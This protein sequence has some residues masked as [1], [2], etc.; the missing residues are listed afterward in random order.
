MAFKFG[1]SAALRRGRNRLRRQDE[2][3]TPDGGGRWRHVAQFRTQIPAPGSNAIRFSKAVTF[4]L[5]F[6]AAVVVYFHFR[7]NAKQSGAQ[8]AYVLADST[9]V[10]DT[11]AEVHTVMT[12]LKNNTRVEV[13]DRTAHWVEVK[14]ADGR[15]GWI[16]A[17]DLLEGEDFEA[18]QRLLKELSGL[19]VQATGHTDGIVNLRLEPSRDSEQLAQLEQNRQVEVFGRRLVTRPANP[20]QPSSTPV[21]EAWYLVRT[22]TRAGWL[23]GRF[24]ELDIPP[25]LSPFAA[26]TNMVAW[27]TLDTVNE[28]GQQV[29]QYLTAE[30][31]GTQDVDF[32]HI[33][34]FTYWVKNHRYVTAYVEG[35]LNGYFPIRVTHSGGVPVFRLR[36]VDEDANKI[37]KVYGLFDTITR[38][39]GTVAGWE[40]EAMPA[41]PPEHHR[42][43]RR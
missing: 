36:L 10:L 21:K 19:P 42:R 25:A 26:G 41:A 43:R 34:V 3:R 6:T 9:K 7:H 15:T 18:G 40:S 38:P 39:L 33:R 27:V 16:E 1:A 28:D 17:K 14:L 32:N 8:V 11:P 20:E 2:A 13:L 23:L 35:D 24:I 29:P 30:R 5:L 31:V 37:Q 12:T 4:L 22:Q